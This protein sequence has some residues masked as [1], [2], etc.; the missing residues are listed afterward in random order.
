MRVAELAGRAV[1]PPL[2]A[3]HAALDPD[4]PDDYRQLAALLALEW[5]GAR[6]R[7]VGVGGGQGAGKSI[8]PHA[9]LPM[10]LDM[11]EVI[12]AGSPLEVRN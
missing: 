9:T 5:A 12:A 2:V 6:P 7:W 1:T 4:A 11:H 3:C 10:L 8:P